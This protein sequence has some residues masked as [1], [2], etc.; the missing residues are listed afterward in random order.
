MTDITLT[1]NANKGTASYNSNP[2]SI[3][4]LLANNCRLSFPHLPEVQFWLQD[5]KLPQISINKVQQLTRYVDTG[6]I[7]EKMNYDPF[8]VSFV[9]DKNLTNWSAIFNWMK[10]ITVQGSATGN[11]ISSTT[12]KNTADTPVLIIN[13]LPFLAFVDSWPTALGGLDFSNASSEYVTCSLTINYD[14]INLLTNTTSDS[15]YNKTR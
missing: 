4:A 5:I 13:N 15:S 9:V 12:N 11:N 1:P 10:S 8:T 7:G 6:E 3:D 14:Y 2:L